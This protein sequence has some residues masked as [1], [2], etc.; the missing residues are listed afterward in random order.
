M[1]ETGMGPC[2]HRILDNKNRRKLRPGPYP[3]MV[4]YLNSFL[5]GT[6]AED[7]RRELRCFLSF[8][9]GRCHSS[10][11]CVQEGLHLCLRRAWDYNSEVC[12]SE[13]ASQL[14]LLQVFFH[15]SAIFLDVLKADRIPVIHKALVQPFAVGTIASDRVYFSKCRHFWR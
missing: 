12:E 1:A 9:E 6:L 5:G 13:D 8:S 10:R 14:R 7:S 2:A 11:S 4:Q 15:M 3:A